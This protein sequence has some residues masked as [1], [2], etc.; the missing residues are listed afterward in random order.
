MKTETT[1]NLKLRLLDHYRIHERTIANCGWASIFVVT[2]LLISNMLKPVD[3]PTQQ[4]LRVP[5]VIVIAT[6][7]ALPPLPTLT[8]WPIPTAVVIIQQAPAPPPVVE[9]VPIYVEVPAQA[10]PVQA[11]PQAIPTPVQYTVLTE[12]QDNVQQHYAN[13]RAPLPDHAPPP[14]PP[15][16]VTRAM[17]RAAWEQE[18][19]FGGVCH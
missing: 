12:R 6:A 14:S 16:D 17:M 8:P 19:C 13:E 10:E 15:D 2:L 11:E 9:F 5:P 4:V 18:H 3:V 7:Q 1:T